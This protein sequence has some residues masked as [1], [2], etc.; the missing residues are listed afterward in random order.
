MGTLAVT[1]S[2]YPQLSSTPRMS[3]KPELA[4]WAIRGLAQPIRLLLAYTGTKF[5]DTKYQVAGTAPNFDKS[6]WFDIKFSLGLDFPNLPYFK[7]G[8]EKLAATLASLEAFL[9]ERP[10]L[11]GQTI[12]FPDFHLYEMLDQHLLLAPN[13][14]ASCPKLRSLHRRFQ[15]LP[16]IDAYMKSEEF[17]AAPI[18][19]L[20]AAWGDK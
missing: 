19:N 4:Y 14:L 8:R 18:N 9:G 10:W 12:S 1:D 3:E 20:Q 17:M 13:C 15:E 2:A 11:C 7:D 6:C 16:A 5:V